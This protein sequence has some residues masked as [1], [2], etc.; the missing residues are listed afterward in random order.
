[1]RIR[2]GDKRR[3]KAIA[4]IW[5]SSSSR[6]ASATRANPSYH[7]IL[8]AFRISIS[9]SCVSGHTFASLFP[10]STS[11]TPHWRFQ[12]H[13]QRN[14]TSRTLTTLED[15]YRCPRLNHAWAD[16]TPIVDARADNTHI[17]DSTALIP[18][19][20]FLSD[21]KGVKVPRN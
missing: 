3:A 11:S 16:T 6:R 21:L 13:F 15:C 2:H 10:F 9:Y 19:L 18:L 12:L 4:F 7:I 17:I 5:S 14:S 1:M 8:I 20:Q